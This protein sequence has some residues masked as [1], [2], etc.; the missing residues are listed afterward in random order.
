MLKSTYLCTSHWLYIFPKQKRA[1]DF[2]V[3]H[4]KLLTLC[5]GKTAKTEKNREVYWSVCVLSVKQSREALMIVSVYL[6][7]IVC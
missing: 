5:K 1:R 7:Y 6:R 2:Y 4:K 3:G